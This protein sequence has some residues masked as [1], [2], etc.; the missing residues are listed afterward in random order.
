MQKSTTNGS[1]ESPLPRPYA[2]TIHT[3]T[4]GLVNTAIHAIKKDGKWKSELGCTFVNTGETF[5]VG[6]GT[7][8]PNSLRKYQYMYYF[9][10]GKKRVNS[11]GNM[12]QTWRWRI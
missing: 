3:L 10:V 7:E 12:W 9:Y 2:Q 6:I 11:P 8:A 5:F 1:N 4:G